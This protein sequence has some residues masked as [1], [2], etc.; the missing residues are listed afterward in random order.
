MVTGIP[1][2][3][4]APVTRSPRRPRLPSAGGGKGGYAA[5]VVTNN[6]NKVDLFVTIFVFQARAATSQM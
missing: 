4:A 2:A 3:A 5:D 1:A 6:L